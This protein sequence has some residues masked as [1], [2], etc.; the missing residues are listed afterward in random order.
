[1]SMLL[2][3]VLI[4]SSGGV[5]DFSI[6]DA[7]AVSRLHLN[8]ND[9]LASVIP[10]KNFTFSFANESENGE[11]IWKLTG[12]LPA[13]LK[14]KAISA[15]ISGLVIAVPKKTLSYP[16][17]ICA[18]GSGKGF[19]KASDF[20]CEVTHLL[21]KSVSAVPSKTSV[22]TPT[23]AKPTTKKNSTLPSGYFEMPNEIVEMAG[24]SFSLGGKAEMMLQDFFWSDVI[25]T[26][27]GAMDLGVKKIVDVNS[28]PSSGYEANISSPTLGH[29]YAIKTR[30]GTYGIIQIALIE[31]DKKMSFF[32][33]YQPNGSTSFLEK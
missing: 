20:D 5:F 17:K 22:P 4:L 27:K 13:G 33:K 26:V 23:P 11:Y 14:F 8:L 29:V 6:A 2:L 18:K 15:T 30:D 28:V 21:V 25:Y 7:S 24:F 31:A 16:L 1:M 9:P 3:A 10:G 32:W 19:A 12:K